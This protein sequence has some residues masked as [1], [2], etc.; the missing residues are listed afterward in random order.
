MAKFLIKIYTALNKN[1]EL[2]ELLLQSGYIDQSVLDRA[3]AK[4]SSGLRKEKEKSFIR[5]NTDKLDMLL[6]LVS[7]L[8]ISHSRI[9]SIVHRLSVHSDNTMEINNVITGLENLT[10]DIQEQV[11]SIRMIPLGPTFVQFNRLVRDLAQKQNKKI[12][13]QILGSET[14]LDKN[15][16]E[17]ISDPLKHMVRNA[18][19]HGLETSENENKEA[20]PKRG[21]YF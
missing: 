16:I 3:L 14:E 17:K 9:Y 2:G 20:S 13:F 10:R 19:D 18:I 21:I 8:I 5:V 6:N 4:K 1:E 7:E 15:M 11:M 12:D